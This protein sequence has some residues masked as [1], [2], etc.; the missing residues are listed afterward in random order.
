MEKIDYFE[1]ADLIE[2]IFSKES[3]EPIIWANHGHE[4]LVSEKNYAAV[5]FY[6]KNYDT[7]SKAM[8]S[9]CDMFRSNI[10]EKEFNAILL[11]HLNSEVWQ[12]AEELINHRNQWIGVWYNGRRNEINHPT[13]PTSLNKEEELNKLKQKLERIL[14]QR[15]KAFDLTLKNN[16]PCLGVNGIGS[17]EEFLRH[18]VGLEPD[19]RLAENQNNTMTR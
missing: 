3:F 6:V 4:N 13:Q 17:I 14:S 7:V 19:W 12:L 18:T 8:K 15:S 2:D 9:L 11:T 10:D 16:F 5:D 1:F